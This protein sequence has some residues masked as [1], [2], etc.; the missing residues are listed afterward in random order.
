[1]EGSVKHYGLEI[2]LGNTQVM[3]I[4]DKREVLKITVKYNNKYRNINTYGTII[5]SRG[6]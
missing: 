5:N 2:N 4:G 1:M 6:T 3:V